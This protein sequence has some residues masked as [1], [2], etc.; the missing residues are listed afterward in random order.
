M[1]ASSHNTHQRSPGS[2]LYALSLYS[3]QVDITEYTGAA[4]KARSTLVLAIYCG[5]ELSGQSITAYQ[6]AKGLAGVALHFVQD[7]RTRFALAAEGG[8]GEVAMR[9]RSPSLSDPG[10]LSH[11]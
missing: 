8:K 4:V 3:L 11:K 10:L 6:Q 2:L 7:E 9:V 5:T 1:L